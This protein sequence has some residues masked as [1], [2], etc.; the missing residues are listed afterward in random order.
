MFTL[1]LIKHWKRL[2]RK[3]L[4][5]ISFSVFKIHVGNVLSNPTQYTVDPPLRKSLDLISC[6][7]PSTLN[8]PVSLW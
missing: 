5:P 2:L 7:V 3:V 8:R 1:R 4:V 6:K